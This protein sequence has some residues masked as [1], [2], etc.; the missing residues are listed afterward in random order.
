VRDVVKLVYNRIPI[1]PLQPL[2][3]PLLNSSDELRPAINSVLN[4]INA[5]SELEACRKAAQIA[6]SL[7]PDALA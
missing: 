3:D 1:A 5:R 7:D 2:L 4:D 6:R